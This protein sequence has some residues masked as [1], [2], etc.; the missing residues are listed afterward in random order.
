MSKEKTKWEKAD[1]SYSNYIDYIS[2]KPNRFTL[3][4]IDLLYVS[5]FKGG[6]ASINEKEE[7]INIKLKK[8][9]ELLQKISENFE[10][11]P[12]TDLTTAELNKLKM[13]VNQ[14]FSLIDRDSMFSIDGF[15][16][17]YASALMH[18]YFPNLIP[19]LDRRALNGAEIKVERNNQGQVK[20]I[21]QHYPQ[22]ID[23]FYS[24]LCKRPEVTLRQLDKEYFIKPIR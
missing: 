4:L 1:I 10:N 14:L 2:R 12:L 21:E 8:Y 24:E 11:R 13:L 19:I 3:T 18:F 9:S 6:N 22:L 23:K 7:F 16:S 17:S 5:N 15:K 20:N